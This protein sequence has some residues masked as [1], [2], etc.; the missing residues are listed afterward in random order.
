MKKL[1]LIFLLAVLASANASSFTV[2]RIGISQAHIRN[3]KLDKDSENTLTFG[4]GRRY[5]TSESSHSYRGFDVIYSQ[6]ELTTKKMS[7]PS[8]DLP[9]E[10]NVEIAHFIIKNANIEIP[11]LVGY[12][13]DVF[14]KSS[15]NLE[16][17]VLLSFAYKIGFNSKMDDYIYL[18]DEERAKYKFDLTREYIE[19]N[20]LSLN[21]PISINFRYQFLG[22]EFRY[23]RAL[24]KI[25]DNFILPN[26]YIDSFYVNMTSFF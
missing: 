24:N 20:P 18:T 4:I 23:R 3:P 14:K 5:Y 15:I 8:S 19:P 1:I 25:G 12:T 9:S 17:G 10:T 6:T 21:L 16:S 26:Q 11:L 22:L 7:Y 2:A 13:H